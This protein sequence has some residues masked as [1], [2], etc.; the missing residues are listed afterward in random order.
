[1]FQQLKRLKSKLNVRN[2]EILIGLFILGKGLWLLYDS[3]YF[4]YPPQFKNIENSRSIDSILIF[5][6][7]FL[8]AAAFLVPYVKGTNNKIKLIILAKVFLVLAGVVCMVLALLQI[9]H[10]ICTPY[11]RMEHPA[12]GDLIIFGFVYLT[13]CDA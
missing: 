3:H 11:Y 2:S 9:T 7:I 5:L 1:M 4:I 10:G 13:A 8:M 6:G 12:W